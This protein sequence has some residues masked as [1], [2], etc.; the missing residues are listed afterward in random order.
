MAALPESLAAIQP[1]LRVRTSGTVKSLKVA[2]A[3]N[4][5]HRSDNRVV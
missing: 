4:G 5:K 2:V 3:S 1:L